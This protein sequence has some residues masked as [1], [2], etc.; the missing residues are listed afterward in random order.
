M[1]IVQ[2]DTSPI[3]LYVTLSASNLPATGKTLTI[4]VSKNGG[5]FGAAGGTVA[6]D[7]GTGFAGWYHY[8][9]TAGEVAT[10]GELRF[11]AT[12]AACWDTP[13]TDRVVAAGAAA[14]DWTSA[15]AAKVDNLDATITSRASAA[16]QTTMAATVATNLDATVSSRASA[17]SLSAG[18]TL[19]SGERTT[20]IAAL[21]AAVIETNGGVTLSVKQALQ[22]AAA[23]VVGK[24][25]GITA[26]TGSQTTLLRSATDLQTIATYTDD[27][28]GNRSNVVQTIP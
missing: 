18:V 3:G 14:V 15:R 20:T 13:F 16:T 28:N 4:T 6:E 24:I 11:L 23:F 12:A 7:T 5:A 10:L 17:T 21:L 22:L 9:P 2:N 19:T 25:S 8:T 1:S 26:G 27:E